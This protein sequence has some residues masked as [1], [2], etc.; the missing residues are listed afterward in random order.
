MARR[1]IRRGLDVDVTTVVASIALCAARCDDY[2][3]TARAKDNHELADIYE[4][5][6]LMLREYAD[7]VGDG[8]VGRVLITTN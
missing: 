7:D 1:N 5:F 4:T 8:V 2:A 6:Q 3:E